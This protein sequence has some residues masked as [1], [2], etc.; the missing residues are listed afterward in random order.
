[1]GVTSVDSLLESLTAKEFTEWM[2]FY[3]IEPFGENRQALNTG[4]IAS[5]IANAN[6]T[7]NSKV[8]KPQDFIP[9]F[10]ESKQSWKEQLS[11]VET[12]NTLY[13]GV[14]KR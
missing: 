10:K 9:E 13:G 4:I 8:F 2:E 12:M 7:K 3:S 5:V 11:I 6:R 14:D 1:L